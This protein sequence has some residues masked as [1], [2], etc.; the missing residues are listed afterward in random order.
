MHPEAA[1]YVVVQTHVKL[2]AAA[3]EQDSQRLSNEVQLQLVCAS[4]SRPGAGSQ[5]LA[6]LL[7]FPVSAMTPCPSWGLCQTRG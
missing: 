2:A 5:V 1:G 7:P 3:T 6:S 4:G